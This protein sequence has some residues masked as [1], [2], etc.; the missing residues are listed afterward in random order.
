MPYLETWSEVLP[1]IP[2]SVV[3]AQHPLID[4]L[5]EVVIDLGL[6]EVGMEK[7]LSPLRLIGLDH[8]RISKMLSMSWQW[9]PELWK[10]IRGVIKFI[11]SRK[12]KSVK[13]RV[14][15]VV[16]FMVYLFQN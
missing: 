14:T 5:H 10:E 13:K 1:V 2:D 9:I 16:D 4:E 12:E 15:A 8:Y 11:A 7:V 3:E 6:Q